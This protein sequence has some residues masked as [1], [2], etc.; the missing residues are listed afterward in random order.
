MI[1]AAPA[2]SALTQAS[3]T[4]FNIQEVNSLSNFTQIQSKVRAKDK[5]LYEQVQGV[6]Y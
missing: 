3:S 1:S 4:T 2:Y 6:G 5:Q